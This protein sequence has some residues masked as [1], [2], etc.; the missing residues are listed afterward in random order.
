[1]LESE[2]IFF[3]QMFTVIHY[4]RSHN[5]DAVA[6]LRF[7]IED[8]MARKQK[9]LFEIKFFSDDTST[10]LKNNLIK[11]SKLKQ[12]EKSA[13]GVRQVVFFCINN[14]NKLCIQ[15]KYVKKRETVAFIFQVNR[16][17]KQIYH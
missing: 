13:I 4:K 17:S 10:Q 14:A 8:L 11:S 6:D 3:P 2:L 5:Y 16:P 7:V 9:A 12:M 1:M 15:K